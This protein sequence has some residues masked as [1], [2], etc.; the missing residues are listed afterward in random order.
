VASLLYTLSPA[1]SLSELLKLP[2]PLLRTLVKRFEKEEKKRFKLSA[3]ELLAAFILGLAGKSDAAKES[4][5]AN[6]FKKTLSFFEAK[7]G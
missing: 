4:M 1:I 3:P 7:R 6:D 2:L 5:D